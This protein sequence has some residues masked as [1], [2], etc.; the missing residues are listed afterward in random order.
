ME[1]SKL[2]E[3]LQIGLRHHRAGELPQ[4]ERAYHEILARDPRHADALHWLGVI[5]HQVRRHEAAVELIDKAIQINPRAASYH[6]NLGLALKAL[7]QVK[8]AIDAYLSALALDPALAETHSNLGVALAETGQLPEAAQSFRAATHHAPNFAG[9][10]DNLGIVLQRLGQRDAAQAAHRQAVRL[11]PLNAAFQTHL[12][13]ALL[14]A[15]DIAGAV[16]AYQQALRSNPNHLEARWG[17]GNAYLIDQKLDEAAAAYH[18]ALALNPNLAEAR[19]NLANVY[20]AQA[21]LDESIR[22]NRRAAALAPGDPTYLSALLLVLNYHPDYD[23]PRIASELSAFEKTFGQPLAKTIEPHLNSRDPDRVLRIGY[24]SADYYHHACAYFLFPL[25]KHHDRRQVEIFLYSSV[26]KPDRF[27]HE[28]Q[29]LPHHWRDIAR[30]SD[31]QLVN[32]V[33]ADQIDIL[34]DL[35]LHTTGSRLTAFARKPAP[36]QMSW[37]GYPGS[38]GLRAIDY[39]ITDVHLDPA[40]RPDP[41]SGPEKLMRLGE[42]FWCYEARADLDVNPLPALARGSF[43]FGCLNSLYKVNE[44]V[45]ELWSRVLRE[46]SRSRM[47]LLTPPGSHC[48]RIGA[49]FKKNDVDPARI[50]FLSPRPR[51]DYLKLYH[52]I[53]LGLDTFPYNGHTTSFDSFWM[54]VPVVTLPGQTPASR[55]GLSILE[56]L[57][58]PELAAGSLEQ[59]VTIA[60]DL[61][62]DLPRLAALRADLRQRITS[63]A[64]MDGPRFALNMESVYRTAWQS[65]C[66]ETPR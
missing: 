34:L 38:T 5:A 23:A 19:G 15:G 35:N 60:I 30:L 58:L 6:G 27:T 36:I 25:L 2:D 61:A 50:Q 64:L 53:D 66:T 41:F 47:L 51:G 21:R 14:E 24:V 1:Q 26:T 49:L 9:A 57:G 16:A 42:C 3:L 54:G 32:Q 46:T 56:N 62:R 39:R 10:Y 52:D 11:A 22:E 44:R 20:K 63:S 55:A 65:W 29:T 45:I 7:G 4:A 17:L 28:F 33:R 31:E 40:D 13:T 37:I 12:A 43:T 48:D 18:A 59:F 8:Q